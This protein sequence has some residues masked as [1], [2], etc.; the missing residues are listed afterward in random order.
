ML[1]GATLVN[2]DPQGRAVMQAEFDASHGYLGY[3]V[4]LKMVLT[5]KSGKTRER[6]LSIE[7]LEAAPATVMTMIRFATPKAIRNTGLLTHSHRLD[8]DDQWIFI[9]GLNR[10]KRIAARDRSGAFVGST[11][12]YEDL[13]DYGVEEFDYEWLREDACGDDLCDVVKRIPHDRYSGYTHHHVWVDRQHKRIRKADLFDGEQRIKQLTVEDY[14]PYEVHGRTMLFPHTM[15]MLNTKTKRA[16]TLL[17]ST[18]RFDQEFTEKRN[19]STSA[20]R[21]VR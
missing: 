13:A 7:Q 3:A 16:T 9:P 8:D 6:T 15:H 2:A 17:W 20:L 10:T 19:F 18:Y 11:F 5:T 1:F 4:N 21:R 12:A 14:R